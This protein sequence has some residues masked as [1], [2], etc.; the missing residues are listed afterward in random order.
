M[1]TD[2]K[3]TTHM[4]DLVNT[5]QEAISFI[6][7][8]A[9]NI[10]IKCLACSESAFIPYRKPF[11]DN[12]KLVIGEYSFPLNLIEMVTVRCKNQFCRW[13]TKYKVDSRYFKQFLSDAALQELEKFEP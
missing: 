13:E 1:N 7:T 10:K 4:L 2:D 9:Y 11:E 12:G 3:E 8:D 6:D 5:P